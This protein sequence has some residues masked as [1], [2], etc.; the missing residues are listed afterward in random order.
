MWENIRTG[1]MLADNFRCSKRNIFL[2]TLCLL[3]LHSMVQ[4]YDE[5]KTRLMRTT[6]MIMHVEEETIHE[7]VLTCQ[8]KN[9]T[10]IELLLCV[11]N[12]E[13]PA[14]EAGRWVYRPEEALHPSPEHLVCLDL[15]KQGNCNNDTA[16][17]L[18]DEKPRKSRLESQAKGAVINS[19]GILEAND[20]WIWE[21]DI[22]EYKILS[23]SQMH[24][25]EIQ[26]MIRG[27]KFYLLG[28]SLTR[29]WAHS[30]RCEFQH[31]FGMSANEAKQHVIYIQQHT[32]MPKD[33]ELA[34]FLRAASPDDYFVL[35]FGH[36]LGP[37]KIKDGTWRKVYRQVLA[38]AFVSAN[39]RK[40]PLDHIFFRTTSVRHFLYGRG[41]WDTNSSL[42]GGTAPNMEAA[43]SMYG[44]HYRSQPEQNILA[45]E[46][47]RNY[48]YQ[49]QKESKIGGILDT[50]P[51]ILARADASFDGSHFCLPGPMDYW[52]RMLYYRMYKEHNP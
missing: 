23:Y 29:Q 4:H 52:S 26:Q 9:L 7:Y 15:E 33:L 47:L 39:Y 3:I 31:V 38:A 51:M 42:S 13:F 10:G 34:K 49:H 11:H 20:P 18:S 45:M 1:S 48:T 6:T 8:N 21:S 24:Q 25:P 50:S 22:D 17:E 16:N 46:L 37:D 14:K 12:S 43:W 30:M 36:H 41:D 32:K 40:I 2:S 28:D 35:N 5:T 44:G 19:P 27:R